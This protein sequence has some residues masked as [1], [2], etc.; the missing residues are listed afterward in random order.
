MTIETTR[1][2]LT[3][4]IDEINKDNNSKTLQ[5]TKNKDI[6]TNNSDNFKTILCKHFITQNGC[7]YGQSCKFAHSVMELK[8]KTTVNANRKTFNYSN[9]IPTKKY[10]NPINFK[11]SLCKNYCKGNLDFYELNRWEVQLWEFLHL[12]T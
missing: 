1:K 5:T 8:P 12:C 11:T 4:Q 3:L 9:Y 7:S 2:L 6:K 10:P